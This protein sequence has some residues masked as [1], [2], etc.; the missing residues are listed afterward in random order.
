MSAQALALGVLVPCHDEARVIERRLQNLL[1]HCEWPQGVGHRLIVVD[2]ASTDGTGE[3]VQRAFA[4]YARADVRTELVT[5]PQRGGKNAAVRRGMARLDD[6]ELIVLTDADVVC[7]P[8]ALRALEQA[9]RDDRGRGG[10]LGLACGAQRFVRTLADDGTVSAPPGQ[11]LED[12]SEGY[13]RWTARVRRLE[14][15][16]GKLFSVHGQLV[17]WPRESGLAPNEPL[18][19]DD[20][21][22]GL[23]VRAAG[24]RVELVADARFFEEKPRAANADEQARR[25]ARGYY[26]VVFDRTGAPLGDGIADRLQWA[27]YRTLPAV[28]PELCALVLVIATALASVLLPGPVAVL[29]VLALLLALGS[30]RARAWLRLLVVMRVARREAA[31][32]RQTDRWDMPRVLTPDRRRP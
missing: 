3:R 6:V 19:A 23:S 14:S 2:D 32:R 5:L 1:V 7:D 31:W 28:F 29:F 16:L 8:D 17:A 10:R 4:A 11:T 9:F 18:A 21:A 24:G 22:L 30:R 27:L 26:Q 25:R 15:R 20:I 13:D 12:A